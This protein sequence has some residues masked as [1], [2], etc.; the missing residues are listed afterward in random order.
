TLGLNA[1]HEV[2]QHGRE[3]FAAM[4][5]ECVG[6]Q[7]AG[8]PAREIGAAGAKVLPDDNGIGPA[9]AEVVAEKT[10][11][12]VRIAVRPIGCGLGEHRD[13]D[14]LARVRDRIPQ[15]RNL[16]R[17]ERERG[18]RIDVDRRLPECVRRLLQRA[19][20]RGRGRGEDGRGDE[21]G[22]QGESHQPGDSI[23]RSGSTARR[24][25]SVRNVSRI[26][27]K[28]RTTF[29]AVRVMR[30][31]TLKLSRTVRDAA[32]RKTYRSNACSV[33]M[34]EGLKGKI[35]DRLSDTWTSNALW[36]VA[37]RENARSS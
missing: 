19:D 32:P 22:D 37:G 3:P 16:R 4:R 36:S 17:G 13:V 26:A 2:E 6:R 35:V 34:P 24:H 28:P 29:T 14:R 11:H 25:R 27:L 15:L 5:V 33:P 12:F 8:R 30:I 10:E 23:A 9:P 18:V 1:V 20:E 7:P 21:G 31:P